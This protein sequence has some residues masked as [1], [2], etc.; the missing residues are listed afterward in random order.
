MIK[1]FIIAFLCFFN[2]NVEAQNNSVNNKLNKDASYFKEDTLH[3]NY[4]LKTAALCRKNNPQQAISYVNDAIAVAIKIS[5]TEGLVKA[6]IEKKK[7]YYWLNQNQKSI[8]SAEK[9]LAY[10]NQLNKPYWLIEANFNLA[11]GYYNIADHVKALRYNLE[12][13]KFA[14]KKE[15]NFRL[16]D[17][18]N[19]IGTIYLREKNYT[20]SL[21]YYQKELNNILILKDSTYLASVFDNMA[22]IDENQDRYEDAI[23]KHKLAIKI[24]ENLKDTN[25]ILSGNNNLGLAYKKTENY[26]EALNKYNIT[27]NLILKIHPIDSLWLYYT[28]LN[29]GYAYTKI[30]DFQKAENLLHDACKFLIR[31]NDIMGITD[32]YYNLFAMNQE[33]GDAKNALQ[34]YLKYVTIKDSTYTIEK[35]TQLSELQ[36]KY[37][38]D[39]KDFE[40]AYLNQQ[41]KIKAGEIKKQAIIRNSLIGGFLLLLLLVTLIFNRFKI[42]AKS[43]DELNRANNDLKATQQ[44]LIQQE[45][46]ASLG[47]LTA[48]IAHEIKNPLNFV[49]NF[50]QLSQELI[51]ELNVSNDEEDKKEIMGHLKAN[52]DKINHH[53]TRA[54]SIVMSM[55]QHARGGEGEKQ[56][57]DINQICNEFT[58]LSFQGMRAKIQDFNCTIEKNLATDLPKI[59]V[60]PQD[61]SRVILNLLNNAF[62]ASN[63]KSI[64]AKSSQETAQ[65]DPKITIT[66]LHTAQN[67]LIKI[68]DNGA[69]IPENVKEKIFEPFFTT[70][71]S[72]E[73]TGLGLSICNDII[74]AHGGKMKV[75]SIKDKFTEFTI[76]LAI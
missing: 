39:K 1:Y 9:A 25:G 69:G 73:G 10:A 45:K 14:E 62:Y 7:C 75:E 68:K 72:G 20:K 4:Q 52:L 54:N 5:Y 2:I 34:Y 18:Y 27:Y 33:R 13:L 36:E 37:N 8:E 40:I 51:D 32:A 22:I 70:K 56:L 19:A 29:M 50:S 15:V 48:G 43:A 42:K 66:T 74:E 71:P 17:I 49:T 24:S 65:Y 6:Y 23:E 60:I 41:N 38:L 46:L 67:V 61:I 44:Q 58:D 11:N 59:N 16:L 47:S 55:L 21:A 28:A 64:S 63:E 3:V 53:G 76:T 57:T 12:A 30:K 31:N 35:A 26:Q